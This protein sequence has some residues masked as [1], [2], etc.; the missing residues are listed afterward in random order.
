MNRQTRKQGA[1]MLPSAIKGVIGAGAVVLENLLPVGV[2][3][4]TV[5]PVLLHQL[6]FEPRIN[7]RLRAGFRFHNG[8]MNALFND[9]GRSNGDS[10]LDCVRA[11][12][13]A[14]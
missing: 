1:N 10:G 9:T 5:V 12:R 14:N 4:G 11:C 8:G 2:D 13:E 3:R 7:A 6:F